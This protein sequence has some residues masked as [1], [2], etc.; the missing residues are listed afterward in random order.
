MKQTNSITGYHAHIYF[1]AATVDQARRLCQQAED[2]FGVQ[3][4]HVHEKTVGPHPMWSCQL[5]ATPEQFSGLLPWL[6]LN[7]D[8]LIVF[9]HPETDDDL[10]DH[11]DHGIWLGTGLDLDFSI[12][13]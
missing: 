7:R 10:A 1:D 2:E 3:M 12:F 4:G 8:G 6:A 5:A 11:R 9:A 13:G